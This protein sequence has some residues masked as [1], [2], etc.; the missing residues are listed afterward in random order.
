MI[1]F[2]VTRIIIGRSSRECV[3]R[4]KLKLVV[5]ASNGRFIIWYMKQL[6][7]R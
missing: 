4:D 6:I 2:V 1:A 3:I 7:K 5:V